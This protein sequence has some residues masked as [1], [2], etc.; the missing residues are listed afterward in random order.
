MR[1][2]GER[3]QAAGAEYGQ[4]CVGIDPHGSLLREWG[5]TD[6]VA[7]LEAFS[8]ICVEAF[9]G[10]VALVKP[11]VAFYERFGAAG[12]AVLEE[13]L[14]Q[15]RKAGTLVVADAKRGDIGSTM[16]G[17]AQAWLAPASPLEVD[18]LTVMPYLGP[19]SLEPAIDLAR[20]HGKGVFV[21]AANSNPEAEDF[22]ARSIG[23]QSVAQYMLDACAA[24][25]AEEL[26]QL[27]GQS[28]MGSVGVVVGATVR[29]PV[30]CSNLHGPVLMPGVG[31]QGATF[32]DVKSLAGEQRELFY[33]SISRAIL[34]AG[35]TVSDLVK[36]IKS[37]AQWAQN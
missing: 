27:E 22:Q 16:A 6:D 26:A 29:F 11:Q 1:S 36:Q 15:L 31:A 2:F 12:F 4:L 3:L 33:P 30:D 25:N 28:D 24:Y 13:L 34:Q 5:L 35:P 20:E 18:A 23:D 37:A 32:A 10:N 7:G 8:A 21:M 17:Y 14:A 9:G 19:G